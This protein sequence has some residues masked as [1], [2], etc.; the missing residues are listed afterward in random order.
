MLSKTNILTT[1]FA[2]VCRQS[3]RHLRDVSLVGVPFSGGQPRS[4]VEHGPKA[5]RD[6]GLVDRIEALG[7]H[8]KDFGDIKV[9]K[10]SSENP[11]VEI[12]KGYPI[13]NSR[14][15]GKV[16]RQVA[17]IV[18]K[19]SKSGD[20]CVTVGGD[21]SIATGSVFGHQKARGNIC[22]LW[23][24]AHNDINTFQTSPSGNL[25]GMCLSFLVKGLPYAQGIPGYEW[26]EPCITPF[27][28]AYIGLRD[29]DPGEYTITHE[30]GIL[31]F[32][33]HEVDRYGISTVVER[34]I[35][36]I[37]PRLDRPI[38]LS[39]DIDSL[40]PLVSPSTGTTVY[41]GLSLREGLYIGE[42]VNKLG[43][44][45]A[46]DLVEVNPKLKTKEDAQLTVQTALRIT[47]ACLG[48]HRS[49]YVTKRSFEY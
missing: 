18:E 41:G 34:A 17:N 40:D 16:S 32:S 21:H 2:S 47:E 31:T 9:D 48:K 25:H 29:T 46:L 36:S 24:D 23:I 39:Y 5:L 4:G 12:Y 44:L 19:G 35:E 26:A 43:L 20:I 38:H 22:V 15:C 3:R 10:Y 37:N 28:I 30:L 45:G 11:E 13:K 14:I 27:D 6:A 8:V 1:C 42:Y 33:M 7:R 49:G